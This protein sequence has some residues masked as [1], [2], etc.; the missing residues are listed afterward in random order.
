MGGLP[1]PIPKFAMRDPLGMRKPVILTYDDR[2]PNRVVH[3]IA[4]DDAGDLQDNSMAGA[5]YIEV[6]LSDRFAVNGA[7][8]GSS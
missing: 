8:T 4:V 1:W 3:R 7:G 6:V 2:N 5:E